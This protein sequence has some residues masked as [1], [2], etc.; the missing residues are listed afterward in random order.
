MHPQPTV[1][2]ATY[3]SRTAHGRVHSLTAGRKFKI[4][5]TPSENDPKHA[6]GKAD[7]GALVS[8]AAT[9]TDE[10]VNCPGCLRPKATR[11]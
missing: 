2:P 4:Y 1:T 9:L 11:R 7:C 10:P 8:T 5:G 6:A 3:G